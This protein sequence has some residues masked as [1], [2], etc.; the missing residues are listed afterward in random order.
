[1]YGPAIVDLFD[2]AVRNGVDLIGDTD[3]LE[4]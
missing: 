3:L 1:M 4:I 2:T